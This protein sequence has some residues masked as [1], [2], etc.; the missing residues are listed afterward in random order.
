MVYRPTNITGGAH[1]DHPVWWSMMIYLFWGW[2][3]CSHP[4]LSLKNS[5][6]SSP[7]AAFNVQAQAD[8][9]PVKLWWERSKLKPQTT[10]YSP[11]K[12]NLGVT[13]KIE[14]Y[15]RKCQTAH[16]EGYQSNNSREYHGISTGIERECISNNMLYVYIYIIFIFIC[17]RICVHIIIIYIHIYSMCMRCVWDINTLKKK[18]RLLARWESGRHVW[19]CLRLSGSSC[20]TAWKASCQISPA[21]MG[22]DQKAQRLLDHDSLA[23]N[24]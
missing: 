17:T 8:Q 7:V 15:L 14:T 20:I 24:S 3:F 12:K 2:E 16:L 11:L 23:I 9:L 13:Q 10:E 18:K 19:H 1:P 5:T 22:Q 6:S 21:K 4:P